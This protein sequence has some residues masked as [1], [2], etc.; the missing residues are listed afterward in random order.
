MNAEP[1]DVVRDEASL[2]VD[3]DGNLRHLLT[4]KGLDK[5]LLTDILDDAETYL[6]APGT[7]PTRT[8]AARH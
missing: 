1:T 8:I 7:L 3:R 6:S 4:L 2:Q 5:S